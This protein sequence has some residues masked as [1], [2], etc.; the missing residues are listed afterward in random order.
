MSKSK[1][2]HK[3]S[4][5]TQK[6]DLADNRVTDNAQNRSATF[7]LV[8]LLLGSLGLVIYLY[9]SSQSPTQ[10]FDPFATQN[11]S[12]PRTERRYAGPA[13]FAFTTEKKAVL[14]PD[15]RVTAWSYGGNDLVR[16]LLLPFFTPL[17]NPRASMVIHPL[18]TPSGRRKTLIYFVYFLLLK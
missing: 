17:R 8:A 15:G 6:A 1:S 5:R 9:Q 10:E 3:K 14:S 4:S 2:R 7:W 12:G 16:L 11:Q 18:I 13:A